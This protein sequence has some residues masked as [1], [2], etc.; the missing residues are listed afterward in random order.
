MCKC[1][2]HHALASGIFLRGYLLISVVQPKKARIQAPNLSKVDGLPEVDI[3]K[4]LHQL[5]KVCLAKQGT[6]GS[7][8][9][10]TLHVLMREVR[11]MVEQC[12]RGLDM[13]GMAVATSVGVA[14]QQIQA[15]QLQQPAGEYIAGIQ[16]QQALQ[17]HQLQPQPGIAIHPGTAQPMAAYP[18]TMTIAPAA[19]APVTLAHDATSSIVH[20][21]VPRS[22]GAFTPVVPCSAQQPAATGRH[23]HGHKAASETVS[24]HEGRDIKGETVDQPHGNDKQVKLQFTHN[25]CR[26]RF[27]AFVL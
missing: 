6:T 9:R 10:D 13:A 7:E 8:L 1:F 15:A 3:W 23:A 19:S 12:W 26:S 20:R 14:A 22:S 21:P 16:L 5:V 18:G 2:L 24:E 27:R 4:L 25:Q 11:D 17:H